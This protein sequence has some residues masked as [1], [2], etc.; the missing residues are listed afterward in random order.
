M[1]GCLDMEAQTNAVSRAVV[2]ANTQ[3]AHRG[4][5][6]GDDLLDIYLRVPAKSGG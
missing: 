5:A 2:H 1:G 3:T 6:T 4:V